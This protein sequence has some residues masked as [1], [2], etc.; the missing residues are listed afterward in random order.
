MFSFDVVIEK[1][2][3]DIDVMIF[4]CILRPGN[5]VIRYDNPEFYFY[6]DELFE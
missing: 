2:N 4:Y 6:E 5:F 1:L 3:N